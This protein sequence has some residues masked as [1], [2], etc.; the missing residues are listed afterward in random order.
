MQYFSGEDIVAFNATPN[1]FLLNKIC[2]D[3]HF[4][5]GGKGKVLT[6]RS[7]NNYLPW[8]SHNLPSK[9]FAKCT[10]ALNRKTHK[11]YYKQENKTET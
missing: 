9:I 3:Q 4:H 1:P 5:C 11:Q 2:L 6:L 10:C 7:K 8:L